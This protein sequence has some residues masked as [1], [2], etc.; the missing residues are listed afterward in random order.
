MKIVVGIVMPYTVLLY[1]EEE[2]D[3][4]LE[5]VT[6]SNTL[7]SRLSFINILTLTQKC[8][9]QCVACCRLRLHCELCEWKPTTCIWWKVVL[10]GSCKSDSIKV[11]SLENFLHWKLSHY[12]TA[13]MKGCL[14]KPMSI[15]GWFYGPLP[16][17]KHVFIKSLVKICLLIE[18]I[19]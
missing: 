19:P 3:V 12:R 14:H 15:E 18:L 7:S 1:P 6:V 4:S 17:S 16:P 10:M 11:D 5:G 9:G 13:S 8:C 2:R